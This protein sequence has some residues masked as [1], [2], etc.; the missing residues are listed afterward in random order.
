MTST[1]AE[2]IVARTLVTLRDY[3]NRSAA[4]WLAELRATLPQRFLFWTT[5]VSR[6][7]F[8]LSLSVPGRVEGRLSLPSGQKTIDWNES[9]FG[10]KTI[11]DLL[12]ANLLRRE[13]VTLVAAFADNAFFRRD[14]MVPK[15]AIAALPGILDQEILYRTPFLP[16]Q[17]W[18]TA[19]PTEPDAAGKVCHVHHWI[20]RRDHAA[21]YLRRSGLTV[22]DIDAIAVDGADCTIPMIWLNAPTPSHAPSVARILRWL[23]AAAT[24][25][26]LLAFAVILFV[27]AHASARIDAEI[28][29]LMASDAA[30]RNGA[31]GVQLQARKAAAGAVDVWG[32]LS[33]LLPD[34]TFLT[35]LRM[36]DGAVTITGLSSNAAQ[37]VRLVEQSPLFTAAHLTGAI[38]PDPAE[39]KDRFSLAFRI[40]DTS[41]APSIVEAKVVGGRQ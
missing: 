38:T 41:V 5:G 33:L 17:I 20:I 7:I 29:E 3:V 31:H 12:A 35:E 25:M 40:R 34:T 36:T 22:D 27:Q 1:T 23:T 16:E 4:W 30:L 19:L 26:P 2:P 18:H 32:E 37:L 10:R 11:A 24:A 15:L 6:P 21:D 13:D 14:L 8:Y 9:A 39:Q 28:E